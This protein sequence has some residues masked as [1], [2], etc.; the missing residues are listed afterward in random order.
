VTPAQA[1]DL[2]TRLRLWP[3]LSGAQGRP[4]LDVEAVAD[5][6][7]RVSL[8]AADLGER[9]VELDVN[10]VIVRAR[11]DGA[12][13]VDCRATLGPSRPGGAGGD[14]AGSA[15]AHHDGGM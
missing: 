3:I 6:A 13:A 9:L 7:R 14:A 11:G 12:V 4:P 15:A 5:I 1:L 2:L 8:L 10:P